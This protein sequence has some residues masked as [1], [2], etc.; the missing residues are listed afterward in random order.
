MSIIA[1]VTYV[2]DAVDIVVV[3]RSWPASVLRRAV[4]PEEQDI[5]RDVARCCACELNPASTYARPDS[6]YRRRSRD[7]SAH[8]VSPAR[9]AAERATARCPFRSIST[10][11]SCA[12]RS[13]A[14]PAAAMPS[15]ASSL[16]RSRS[17]SAEQP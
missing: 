13:A 1:G 12:P 2:N 4:S 7:S 6:S 17:T 10:A 5:C 16:T 9:P 3:V 14:A 15:V 11:S 8:M